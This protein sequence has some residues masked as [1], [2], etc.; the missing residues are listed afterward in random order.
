MS[1]SQI[2]GDGKELVILWDKCADNQLAYILKNP[3]VSELNVSMETSEILPHLIRNREFL[4]MNNNLTTTVNLTF[5]VQAKDFYE[6]W[7]KDLLINMDIFRN[8]KI[9]DLFKIIN[10]K[11]NARKG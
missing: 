9:S 5:K 3:L 11:I 6:Q 8:H 1:D 10:K 2:F 7:G 4:N